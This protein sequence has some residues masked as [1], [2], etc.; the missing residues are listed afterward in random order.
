MN[1]TF[2]FFL[3]TV[4][5]VNIFF[6]ARCRHPFKAAIK[7]ALS[8]IASLMVINLLSGMTTVGIGINVLTVACSAVLG[9]SGTILMLIVNLI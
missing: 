1:I 2:Y 9:I 6:I 8:G 7:S 5:A 4:A 3:I